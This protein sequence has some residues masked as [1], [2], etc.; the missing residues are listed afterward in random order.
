MTRIALDAMGGDRAPQETVKGAVD[1]AAGG[2]EVVLVGDEA[3]LRPLLRESGADLPVV[4]AP[5]QIGM[6]EDVSRAIRD[7][8]R[9]SIS[10]AARLVAEGEADGL[11]SAGST[12]ATVAAGA[13]LVGRAPGVS[14]PALAAV[15]PLGHPTVVL[16]IGAN[17]EVRPEH[18]VQF[19]VMGSVLAQVYLG[20]EDPA[21][22][23]L[24][25]GEEEGKGRPLEK[26]SFA[27]L[28]AAPLRFAGNVEG[29]DLGRGAAD[30]FVTDGFSGNVLL[31]GVE[32][33]VSAMSRLVLAALSEDD[34][35]LQAA[36]PVVLPRLAVLRE[37]LDPDTHGGA[38]LLGTRGT[39]VVAHGSASRVA[40][41]NALRLAS[42]GAE[43]GLVARVAEGLA[44][45]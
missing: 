26:E 10:V 37:S 41:A 3:R 9:A 12:G 36:L 1:A 15:F 23:L 35:A 4:H 14:R 6:G 34:P 29:R 7:K 45:V 8:K 32:G 31:K 40:V 22:G 28:A 21:V 19:G 27:L 39:V 18:L 5:E 16:D 30:V 11:V 13:I 44:R 2:V 25:V 17:L 20:V 24:N 38:H 43:R 42:A 33:T